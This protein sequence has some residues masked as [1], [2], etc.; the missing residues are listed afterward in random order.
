MYIVVLTQELTPD[1]MH[2]VRVKKK[3]V[4]HNGAGSKPKSLIDIYRI[5]A[6]TTTPITPSLL[7][8]TVFTKIQRFPAKPFRSPGEWRARPYEGGAAT[9][10]NASTDGAAVATGATTHEAAAV[11]PMPIATPPRLCAYFGTP[12][13]SLI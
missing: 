7:H 6:I 10:C 1:H 12:G 2:A 13:M 4:N 9:T 3:D 8:S 11:T 5:V